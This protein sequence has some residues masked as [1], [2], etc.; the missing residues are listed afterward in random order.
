MS[1]RLA[2]SVFTVAGDGARG[3]DLVLANANDGL[4]AATINTPLSLA[5]GNARVNGPL[6]AAMSITNSAAAPAEGLD[7]TLGGTTG[8]ATKSG[9]INLLGAGQ[10]DA[11]DIVV[12]LATASAGAQSGSVTLGFLSDGTGTDNNGTTS[13]PGATVQLSGAVYREAAPMI[14]ALPQNF[15]VHVGDTVTQALSIGNAVTADGYSEN[16]LASIAGTSGGITAQ[17]ATGD[18]A[19]QATS[20]AIAIGFSTTSAGSVTGSVTLNLQS[21][22]TGIDGLGMAS[23]GQQTVMVNATVDNFAKTVLQENSGGGTWSKNANNYTLN[24]GTL[25]RGAAPVV[26]NLGVA[27]GVTGPADLLSGSFTTTTSSG[28]TLAGFDAFSG[29]GAGQ[30]D[31]LPTVTLNTSTGGTFTETITL[32]T[33]GSNS[34]GYSG[35][36][37]TQTLTITGIIAAS[38]TWVGPST[39]SRSGNWNAIADWS[40]ALLPTALTTAVISN[41]GSYTVTSTQSNSVGALTL[42]DAAATLAVAGGTFAILGTSSNA[43]TI[44]VGDGSALQLTGTMT[45]TGT[46]ALNSTGDATDLVI[47]GS[48]TLRGAGR[49]ALGGAAAN[50]IVSNGTLEA[51]T[52]QSTIIGSGM[53]GDSLLSVTNSAGAVINAN[54]AAAGL[55]ITGAGLGNS[56]LVEATGSAGLTVAD[57]TV[58]GAGTIAAV[59]A[60]VYLAGATLAS[61]TLQSSVGGLIETVSG[62]NTLSG[63]TSSGTI[64][65][66]DGTS[67]TLKGTITN[68]GTIALNASGQLVIAGGTAVKGL[69]RIMLG[70]AAANA[71]LSNGAAATL[72]NQTTIAGSGVIGDSFLTLV[73]A[74]GGIIDATGTAASLTITGAHA[75]SNYGLIEA[76]GSAGLTIANTTI[77]EATGGIIAA[78]GANVYLAGATLNSDALQSSAGGLIETVGGTNTLNG[79]TSSGTIDV[80][81]GT[82][83]TL[84]GTITNSGTIALNASGQLVIA[85]ITTARGTGRIALGDAAANAIL[86]NGAA[87]T[88]TNQTTIAGSGVIGDSFLMLVNAVGGIIDATGTAASLTINGTHAVSNAGLIEATGGA[89]LTI[90]TTIDKSTGGIIAAAGANVYLAGATLNNDTLQTSSGG[91]IETVSGTNTLSGTTSSGTIDVTD[92]TSLTL[93]G[94]ITNAGTIALNASGRLAIAGGTAVKGSGRI[95]LGDAAA[96]AILSNG[97]AATLTNQ[98]TIAG[99]GVIGDSFLMLANAAGGIIDATGTAASLTITGARGASNGGLIE[100]TGGAGLFLG[101]TITEATGGVIAAA[102][103]NVYLAGATL[104][105]DTLQASP[106]ALIE[107]VSGVNT[108]SGTTSSGTIAVTDGTSLALKGTITDNGIIALNSAGHA[109]SL[110]IAGGV[111]LKGTGAITMTDAGANTIVSNGFAELLTNQAT[112]AGSGTIGDSNITLT[113]AAGATIDATGTANALAINTGSHAI[114]NSGL[115]E[116]TA[117]GGLTIASALVNGGTLAASGGTLTVAGKVTGTGQATIAGGTLD[118]GNSVVATQAVTFSQGTTGLLQLGLAQSFAGT[119]AGLASGDAIDLLDF[120]FATNPTISGVTAILQNGSPVGAAVTVKDGALSATISLLNQSGVPYSTSPGAYALASDNTGLHPGTLLELAPPLPS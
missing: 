48:T 67:L 42:S 66:T 101:T 58:S 100:A 6:G 40:P 77:T 11:A 36:L 41:A 68:A 89:G 73:N 75:A 107:T 25:V 92:G 70:D 96:N 45:N 83:L 79:T 110:V 54:G 93:K 52:N 117:G 74:V 98:T 12:G 24:L 51:L 85:G 111:T 97:A 37:A 82:S 27:N 76:T 81:D 103:A 55:T 91:L 99:S 9:S 65:V 78:A 60:N 88:L 95:A 72:T 49:I 71:I 10:T 44:T 112:I 105:G 120:Q 46:I 38:M 29:L 43:G 32:K 104:N 50:A 109:T 86:S 108:L 34:S 14:G 23:L 116:A 3:S 47:A 56:G 80:T 2:G 64:D 5:L 1:G 35:A 18:I 7:V 39:S 84:K 63:T 114:T 102:G 15:V 20:N 94:T 28:F 119:V 31:N 4:A 61:G 26:V 115:V 62:T 16:L 22:G 57:T 90:G 21:D 17:G 8:D 33:T 69:G 118:F 106:G 13:L 30:A 19:P 87:A 59:G 113:N 53:I